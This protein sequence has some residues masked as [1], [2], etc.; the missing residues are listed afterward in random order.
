[1]LIT[2]HGDEQFKHGKIIIKLKCVKE[3][4]KNMGSV[5]KIDMLLSSVVC[6]NKKKKNGTKFFFSI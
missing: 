6:N 1:M 3:Y 5:D 2:I 4:K